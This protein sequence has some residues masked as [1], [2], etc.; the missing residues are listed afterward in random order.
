MLNLAKKNVTRICKCLQ[1]YYF[2]A[3]FLLE[4]PINIMNTRFSIRNFLSLIFII[5]TII[6]PLG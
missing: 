6:T 2:C 4:G 5:R 1:K 3:G